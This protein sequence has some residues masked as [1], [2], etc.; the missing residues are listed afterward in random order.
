MLLHVSVS[1][2]HVSPFRVSVA[3][4]VLIHEFLREE[5]TLN[6]ILHILLGVEHRGNLGQ[7]LVSPLEVVGDLALSGLTLLG[8]DQHHAV[9][10]LSTVDGSR[11][12]VLQDF[13]RGDGRGVDAADVGEAHTIDNVEGIGTGIRGI[14]AH[15]HCRR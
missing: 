6:H 11:S 4:S 14:T 5:L 13:H 2:G 3:I 8:G 1:E 10:S 15:T 12:S 9:T 7:A